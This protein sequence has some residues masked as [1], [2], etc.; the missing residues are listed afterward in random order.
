M[1]SNS[2]PEKRRGSKAGFALYKTI[3]RLAMSRSIRFITRL[4]PIATM[5]MPLPPGN[6]KV[7]DGYIPVADMGF[8]HAVPGHTDRQKVIRPM[9]GYDGTRYLEKPLFGEILRLPAMPCGRFLSQ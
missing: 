4:L 9:G 1:S 3:V 5:K 6:T 7:K 2:G 8:Y